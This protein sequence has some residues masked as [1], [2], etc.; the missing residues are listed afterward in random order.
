M[1][2]DFRCGEHSVNYANANARA[3][4]E[5]AEIPGDLWTGDCV[6]CVDDLPDLARRIIRALNVD[7]VRKPYE[8]KPAQ[9]GRVIECGTT[10]EMNRMRLEKLLEIVRI[11]I[12]EMRPLTWG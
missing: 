11:G 5:M 6:V 2:V 7:A 1:S 3:V 8:R 10:D 9:E 4:M 12:R